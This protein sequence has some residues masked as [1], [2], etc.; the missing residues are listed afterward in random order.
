MTL[1]IM[2]KPLALVLYLVLLS[3]L[4]VG[5]MDKIS[6]GYSMKNVPIPNNEEFRLE[7]IHSV[8]IFIKNMSWRAWHYLNPSPNRN[9][10]ETFSF[11]TTNCAPFVPALKT[12]Q[13]NMQDLTKKIEFKENYN[14]K[15]QN[16]LKKDLKIIKAAKEIIVPAD[17]S[18]NYYKADN[19]TYEIL[20]H[21]NITKDYKK[22]DESVI[23]KID[24]EDRDIAIN[25]EIDDR[26]YKTS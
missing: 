10:K 15:F 16:Q 19:E 17:K 11:N 2:S 5:N 24:K 26:V 4:S 25:L 14:N 3:P 20:L 18:T 13:D 21:R 7:F 23:D 6:F 22:A 1:K 9:K 8:N 12:L